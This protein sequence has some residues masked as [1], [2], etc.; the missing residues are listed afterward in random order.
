MSTEALLDEIDRIHDDEPGRA[1][2]VLRTLDAAALPAGQLP[3]YGFLLLHVLG[4]ELGHWGE[5]ADRLDALRAARV[6]AP[7]AVLA[8][9]ATAAH[10]AQRSP[11]PAAEALA[12]MGGGEEEA[13]LTALGALGSRPPA[14]AQTQAE[15]LERLAR[16]SQRFDAHGPLNQRLALGFSNATSNLLDRAP[17]P[18]PAAIASALRAGADAALRFWTAAGNWVNLERALYLRALVA[19]RIGDHAAARD[20][21]RQALRVIAANGDEAVDRAFLQLQLA[22]ALLRLG[23]TEGGQQALA[24][25]KAS[26]AAWDDAGLRD[27]FRQEH[28]RLFASRETS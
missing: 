27:W 12:A 28:D 16:A 14:Q 22:A 26:A 15:Q 20:D 3:R 13:A 11:N 25:A 1:V 19:N 21:C 2:D 9:A 17:A 4:E 23:E 7:L 24:E 6:D 18:V 10:L 8:Q 5:A